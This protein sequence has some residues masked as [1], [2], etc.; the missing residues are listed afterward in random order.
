MTLDYAA[1]SDLANTIWVSTNGSAYGNAITPQIT[2]KLIFGEVTLDKGFKTIAC[3]YEIKKNRLTGY[4]Y[5]PEDLKTK[6]IF[7]NA[8]K[9]NSIFD[10]TEGVLRIYTTKNIYTNYVQETND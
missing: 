6:F 4:L 1:Y 9:A 7:G 2:E 8:Q 10:I 3:Q 5:V